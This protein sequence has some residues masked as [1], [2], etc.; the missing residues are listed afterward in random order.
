M[1]PNGPVILASTSPRRAALLR[2]AGIDFEVVPPRYQ[3]PPHSQWPFSPEAFAT[4]AS[5]FKARSVA[6]DYPGRVV[7]GADTVVA[8][9]GRLFGKPADRADAERILR[10][11]CGTTQQVITGVALCESVSG[12]RLIAH[13]TTHVT[14]RRMTE[15]ELQAYLD[16]GDWEGKAGAYGIQD[17]AD[18]FVVRCEGSFSNV[19][20]LPV[21]LLGQMLEAFGVS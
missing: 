21:E 10:V 19:V 14:M 3:E 5:Y 9:R 15:L 4:S 12:R 13:D 20:G 7:L 8:V 17:S 6:E 18:R 11:L 16:S 1:S 2:E